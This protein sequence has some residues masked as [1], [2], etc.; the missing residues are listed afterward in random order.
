MSPLDTIGV[1]F[2]L[3][4]LGALALR[5][6]SRTRLGVNVRVAL[7][8]LDA[9]LW[10][11]DGGEPVALPEPAPDAPVA[12]SLTPAAP[13]AY[14][15]RVRPVRRLAADRP[16]IAR[17]SPRPPGTMPAEASTRPVRPKPRRDGVAL[18]PQA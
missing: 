12:F 18:P 9:R 1:A 16:A 2:D 17:P 15:R 3:Y 13:V 5:L 10:P 11:L 7:S 14:V 6:A 4:G 8:R